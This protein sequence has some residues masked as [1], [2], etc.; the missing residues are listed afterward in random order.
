MR[1][2]V[3]LA[4][5]MC[6]LASH[7]WAVEKYADN[8]ASGCG[9]S[10]TTYDPATR[11]CGGGSASMWN[12]IRAAADNLGASNTLK[13][14]SGTYT[15]SCVN[16]LIEGGTSTTPTRIEPYSGAAV[17]W[18][19]GT[20]DSRDCLISFASAQPY[21]TIDGHNSDGTGSMVMDGESRNVSADQALLVGNAAANITIKNLELRDSY[22]S[23]ITGLGANATVE[24]NLIHDCGTA[25]SY[26][27]HGVY[28]S[29]ASSVIRGN[30]FH[31]I[32]GYAIHCYSGS[33]LC[34][35]GTVERNKIYNTGL[36]TDAQS[37]G[38]LIR[39][40]TNTVRY[41]VVRCAAGSSDYGVYAY[42]TGAGN[43]IEH[44]SITNCGTGVAIDAAVSGTYVR[45]NAI[46]S[47]VTA[48][49]NSGSGTT[50]TTNPTTDPSWTDAATADLT[51]ASG[52]AAMDACTDIGLSFNG[53]A[54]D[55]G[56]FETFT[57]TGGTVSGNTLDAQ[58]GMA[59]N[60]PIQ[61]GTAGWTVN[62]GRTVTGVSLVGSSIVRLTFSGAACAGESWTWSYSGGTATD[63]VSIGTINQ[64]LL[65]VAATAVTNNCSGASYTFTQAAFRFADVHALS[66]AATTFR[67]LENTS[68]FHVVRGGAVMIRF[69][70]V[71]GGTSCPQS[72]FKLYADQGSGYSAVPD[73]PGGGQIGFC[74]DRYHGRGVL[75]D[76]TPTS[77]QLSVGGTFV[78]GGVMYTSSAVPSVSLALGNKTEMQYCVAFTA[79]ASGTYP[80]RIFLQ[81]GT[82]LTAYTNTP[83]V[84]II[85]P[86]GSGD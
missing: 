36:A 67:Q 34:S 23:C 30:T 14:Q 62:N 19:K 25:N 82:P 31:T 52:S 49:S 51:L 57:G 59:F 43:I 61:P 46:Y 26:L 5:L 10:S 6:C 80:F 24:N 56:A 60:A 9:T 29:G 37:G 75:P 38:I 73:S 85:E 69:A 13:I 27:W 7:A 45:N 22:E 86:Q 17:V 71:C 3:V 47:N 74:G 4:S 28:Y 21:V 42:N 1:G 66:E 70:I 18:N 16:A 55:C 35:N 76:P 78:S 44:N 11:S 32:Y 72:A 12:T 15:E 77:S 48:V 65:T 83:V 50:Q 79:S 64:P 58:L 8:G 84:T 40:D 54:P 68:L 63:S 2:I 39:G 41:N 33:T 20:A 81:D 53:A